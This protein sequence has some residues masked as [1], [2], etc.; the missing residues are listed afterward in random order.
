MQPKLF[1]IIF[2]CL[3]LSNCTNTAKKSTIGLTYRTKLIDYGTF[4][5]EVPE[6]WVNEGIGVE[7][8]YVGNI[9]IGKDSLVSF[10]LG[11]YS[12][13]L[14]EE[15][16]E[17]FDITEGNVYVPDKS[18]RP[19]KRAWKIFGKADSATLEKVKRNKVKWDYIDNYRAKLV[20]PK[21]KG[22]GT[23]GV[24]F[25]SLWANGDS[26]IG[27]VLARRNLKPIHQQQLLN[28]VYSLHFH[29]DVPMKYPN[30]NY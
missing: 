20:V 7:D 8:S 4:I 1:Y 2:I 17:Y 6:S 23:T 11:K 12:N 24:Y 5:I 3:L 15:G 9:K 21:I 22:I 26:K 19:E 25:D 14:N 28:A 18:S 10:D 30:K 29:K 16:G 13:S 27:F